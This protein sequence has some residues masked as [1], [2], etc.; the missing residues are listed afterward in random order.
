MNEVSLEGDITVP[1]LKTEDDDGFS[2]LDEPVKETVVCENNQVT[3]FK[4]QSHL[5]GYT[6]ESALH[7]LMYIVIN[8]NNFLS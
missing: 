8:T 4:H 2:T 7:D 1:G 3:M 5:T 6:D